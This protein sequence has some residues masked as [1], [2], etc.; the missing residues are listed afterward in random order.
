MTRP[1][2]DKV[3]QAAFNIAQHYI[4]EAQ[5]LDLFAG[6]GAM[7]IEAL[8]RGAQKATFIEKNTLALKALRDN[9]SDLNLNPQSTVYAG[10]VLSLLP[11]LKGE[12][13]D[14][15]YIDPPYNKG[16]GIQTLALIDSLQL[17]TSNGLLFLE[18]GENLSLPPLTHLEAKKKRK[19][20]NTFLYQFSTKSLHTK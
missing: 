5:F 14:L 1:T 19:M 12:T 18:E 11:K 10:D 2:S 17:L 20:G 16:L 4:E 6:S 9:L 8:S 3:R 15:I 13:Y 7:G